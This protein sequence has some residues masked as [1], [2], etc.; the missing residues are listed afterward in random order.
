M[1]RK[2]II[3]YDGGP[4][5]EDALTLGRTISAA[6]GGE[7]VVVGVFPGGA[8]VDPE[9]QAAFAR[10]VE[11]AADDI[12]APADAFPASSPARGLHDAAEELGAD[13]VVVG[14]ASHTSPGHISAGNVAVQML[15]GSPCAVAVAPK[16][17]HED[18]LALQTIG[19][20]LDGGSES[21]EALDAA[22]ALAQA[23]GASLRLLTVSAPAASA[24]GWGYGVFDIESELRA[25]DQGHLDEAA[26][27]VPDGIRVETR[28]QS[29]G[30]VS[31]QLGKAAEGVDLL[32]LGSRA[33]GP[34]RRVVLGSVSAQIVKDAP[35][36]VLVL[37]RG[38]TAETSSDQA[39]HA[40][41]ARSS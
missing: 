7:L 24:F 3:G 4:T 34:I 39:H 26:A 40:V 18:G 31:P 17:L 25:I 28:V 14:S 32:C 35:C 23:T 2:I 6:T 12:G 30:P 33:Y 11:A 19:V 29:P 15:H 10:R 16:G 21:E 5:A 9:Q 38:V 1:Y 27:R 41:G 8:F 36:P 20:A 22:I 37:P 13:L